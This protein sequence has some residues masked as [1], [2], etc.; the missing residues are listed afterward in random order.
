MLYDGCGE[1]PS[2]TTLEARL[3]R[4]RRRRRLRVLCIVERVLIAWRSWSGEVWQSLAEGSVD[5]SLMVEEGVA[6]ES[7]ARVAG[8]SSPGT[9]GTMRPEAGTLWSSGLDVG[10]AQPK[11]CEGS[12]R[13]TSCVKELEKSSGC[14]R[15]SRL[16]HVALHL[17]NERQCR[18]PRVQGPVEIN[19]SDRIMSCFAAWWTPP[20]NP[21][22]A[23]GRCCI[24][25][26]QS[27]CCLCRHLSLVV[28]SGPWL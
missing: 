6:K 5:R 21:L 15:S 23:T 24:P 20:T 11:C 3:R 18:R 2:P 26:T 17:M 19:T 12:Y 27:V 4:L 25:A 14:E 22:T 13:L 10:D 8:P 9:V 7:S 28:A 1:C 16:D